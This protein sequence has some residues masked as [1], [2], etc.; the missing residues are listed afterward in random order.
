MCFHKIGSVA[1]IT[2][3]SADNSALGVDSLRVFVANTF[4]EL[5]SVLM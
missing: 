5:S 1:R 3:I 2:L 4:N